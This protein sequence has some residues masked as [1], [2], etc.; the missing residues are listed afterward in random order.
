M[1][2][3]SL[4]GIYSRLVW[5]RMKMF[6]LNST[7]LIY[8]LPVLRIWIKIF[9]RNITVLKKRRIEKGCEIEKYLLR[10][11]EKSTYRFNQYLWERERERER[12][13]ERERERE[14]GK[15]LSIFVSTTFFYCIQIPIPAFNIH[16]GENFT[17]IIMLVVCFR[18]SLQWSTFP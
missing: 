2:D 15:L 1:Q 9:N 12:K 18:L 3:D 8:L 6:L 4:E 11:I 5:A 17:V 13:R 7:F 16:Y 14:R 10:K